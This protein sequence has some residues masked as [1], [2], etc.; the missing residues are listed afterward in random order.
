MKIYITFITVLLFSAFAKAQ[1]KTPA[2][3]PAAVVKQTVGL[4]DIQIMYSRPAVKGRSIF[5]EDGLIPLREFWRLGANAATKYSFSTT[6]EIAGQFLEKG[7]YTIL[8][9]PDA[10]A[11][12][13]FIYPYEGSNW[14]SYKTKTP[15]L[16]FVSPVQKTN[17]LQ[18]SFEISIQ[19]ITTQ[20]AS[21]EFNWEWIKVA[22]PISV[23]TIDAVMDDIESAI[24]GP[25]SNDYFQA[26]L[27]M[28]DNQ[29][30]LNKALRYIQEVTKSDK[31][32]FFQVYREAL[33]LKDLS[34]TTEALKAA[35]RSL[36]LSIEAENT[37]FIRLNE[38]LIASF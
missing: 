31:A 26:A 27:F 11:W 28:H 1:L 24:N 37:D 9:K 16:N 36:T 2:L 23:K 32:L 18:E 25:S 29:L 15:L 35:E 38:Q 8:V 10:S 3:S 30:D 6:I 12:E 19:Q 33:I 20:M 21:L 7:D 17:N 5:G 22:V 13:F 14:N 4:T 34:K